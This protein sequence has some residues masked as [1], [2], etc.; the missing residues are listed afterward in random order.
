MSRKPNKLIN[1]K[2]PYLLQHAYN[3]VEWFPWCEEAFE[4][5]KKEDKPIFLSI[6][7]STCHWCH[8]M[9]KESFEDEEVAKLMNETFVSIKVDREERPDIDGIYMTVCQMITGSG[10]WPLTIIMTPDKKPFFAGTYFPK[11]D[12]FGRIGMLELI[13]KLNDIWKNRKQEVLNSADEITNSIN[14]ISLKKSD[15]DIDEN[16]LNKAFEEF[17]RRFDKQFGGFGNAPKFP[18]PHNL[19]F[20]LRYYRKTKNPSALEMVDKTLTEMR[21]G[22]IYDH[23]GFGFARY[24]TDKYWLVPHF[25]KMLYDNALLLMAFTEAFQITGKFIFRKTAEEII[26]YILRDMTHPERGFYSAEDAD[27]EGEEGKF[28]LWTEVEVRQL[29]PQDEADFIINV[30]NLEPN[31]NWHDEARGI[32]TGNNI[33]H[34]KKT[35]K[36]LADAFSMDEEKFYEKLNSIRKKMFEWREKR[37][38]PHKD[39]KIL[40]DWNSLMISALV[41]ASLVFDNKDYFQAALSA[42]SFIKKYLYDDKKLLHR[43]RDGESAIDANLDDYAFYIQAQLDLFEATSDA[44]FL[45]T[46]IKLDKFLYQNFWDENLGGYF[47]TSVQS[48]KLIARQK[49]IY[50]GAIPSGNSVQLLNLIRL[51]KITSNISYDELAIKQVRAFAGEINRMPS[52]FAQFLCGLDFFF[53]PSLE[54]IITSKNKSLTENA[55][56]EVSKI[57]FPDKVIIQLN[58]NNSSELRGI[59]NYLNDYKLN[60]EATIYLCQNFVCEKPTN[61]L[62]EVIRKIETI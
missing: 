6:G 35:F 47:F 30:F 21:K 61:N 42:D 48:E 32:R 37:I 54:I 28:Y 55:M 60:D 57:Y 59:L 40:T 3:P 26:E 11:R 22:G 25:E 45:S 5:A 29:L 17:S 46:A 58:E 62:D 27:S 14:K 31:G 52:V 41:R 12:R 56:K 38:H 10:G 44:K 49:E 51:N 18:T 53:G 9:E 13:P 1:E 8:V 16:I 23:I 50:D 34:L 20:L 36:E 33:L 43:F 15:E 4:K 19:L 2:S 24:S 39:D 7:Y